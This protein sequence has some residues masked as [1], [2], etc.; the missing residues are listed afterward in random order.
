MSAGD[1]EIMLASE[2]V[3]ATNIKSCIQFSNETRK[4][5]NA[6]LEKVERL[7]NN[8]LTYK[9]L[10]EQQKQQL[11]ILQGRFYSAGSVSYADKE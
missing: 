3:Q 1:K 4:I 2:K 7:E 9:T 6:L 5:V 8:V 11:A 10:V